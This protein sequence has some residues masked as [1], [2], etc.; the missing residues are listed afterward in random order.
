MEWY[1]FALYGFF[2]PLL[3]KLFF[4]STDSSSELLLSFLV[5]GLGFMAR[6]LGGVF[7]GYLSDKYGRA[8]V[9]KVTPIVIML[10]TL[11]ICLLP[12]YQTLGLTASILL[13]IFRLLQGLCIAGEYANNMV[14]LSETAKKGKLFFAS[15]FGSCAASSGILLASFASTLCYVYFS[16]Y[17]LYEFGWRLPFF[18]SIILCIVT[19]TLRRNLPESPQFKL[20]IT[21]KNPIKYS[22]MHQK[23]EYFLAFCVT[24]LPATAFYFIFVF[25]PAIYAEMTGSGSSKSMETNTG[26]LMVR[27]V[28]IPLVGMLADRFGGIKIAKI[29]SVLFI[30]LSIPVFI[31]SMRS[32]SI[33]A[34]LLLFFMG[35]LTTLNA[36][37]TPGILATLFPRKTRA[38]T[39]SITLNVCFGVVGGLTPA[40]SFYAWEMTHNLAIPPLF[41]VCSGAVTFLALNCIRDRCN[42]DNSSQT[43]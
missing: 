11:A 8:T 41:L 4:P 16:E 18:A 10:P 23:Q 12:S 29:S 42:H 13:V 36:G 24:Y 35:L 15:S 3:G 6:P 7:F 38:T 27:L 9:L 26:S 34:Q 19:L 20:N 43:G 17:N 14:Y 30:I 5:F 31:F 37:T 33:L 39:M 22:L 21:E 40:V 28:L 1:D 32:N 25:W 2:A